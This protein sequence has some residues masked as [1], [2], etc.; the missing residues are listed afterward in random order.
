M[1][2]GREGHDW[3]VPTAPDPTAVL[4]RRITAWVI[5]LAMFVVLELVLIVGLGRHRTGISCDVAKSGHAFSQC[6]SVGTN[7]W[8]VT[9]GRFWAALAVSV[10]WFV[11]IPGVLQGEAAAT[12]GKFATGLRVVRADGYRCGVGRALLRSLCWAIDG[13]PV[14]LGPVVG[15]V[16][17]VSTRGHRRVGDLAADTYVVQRAAC[18]EALPVTILPAL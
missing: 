7:T 17:M 1:A 5:D 6:I 11:L 14:L 4:L 13:F 16:A 12:P 3:P 15:G 9:G 2:A 8:L 10:T 18:G